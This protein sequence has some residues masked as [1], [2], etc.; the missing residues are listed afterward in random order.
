VAAIGVEALGDP[1]EVAGAAAALA[2][3]GAALTAAVTFGFAVPGLD[4]TEPGVVLKALSE[5]VV[6]CDAAEIPSEF[7]VKSRPCDEHD[8]EGSVA[9]SAKKR[10]RKD[11]AGSQ[12]VKR[13]R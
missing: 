7:G 10:I 2:E 12:A 8:N 5:G 13:A 3:L 11:I 1:P 4:A 6:V 9:A